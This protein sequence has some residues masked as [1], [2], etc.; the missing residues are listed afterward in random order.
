MTVEEIEREIEHVEKATEANTD[1]KLIH[2]LSAKALWQI[3][4]QLAIMNKKPEVSLEPR[5][6]V[7]GW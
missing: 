6:S 4:L 1:L 5:T 3:A 7:S 2:G